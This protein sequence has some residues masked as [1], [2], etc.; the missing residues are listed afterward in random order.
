[1]DNFPNKKKPK[2][3][4]RAKKRIKKQEKYV[5]SDKWVEFD[6]F[7]PTKNYEVSFP[8]FYEKKLSNKELWKQILRFLG[9]DDSFLDLVNTNDLIELGEIVKDKCPK[10]KIGYIK[11]FNHLIGFLVNRGPIIV[12][13]F[14]IYGIDSEQEIFYTTKGIKTFSVINK[15]LLNNYGISTTFH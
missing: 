4:L 10:L 11:N 12:S 15:N 6:E 2:K 13:D 1:M 9:Y 8:P 7:V 5:F 14:I 3:K